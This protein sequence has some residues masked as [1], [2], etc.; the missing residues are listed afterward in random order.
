MATTKA[1]T[2]V[3]TKSST[4][5]A[6][7]MSYEQE[8]EKLRARLTAPSGDRIKI[9]N[10]TFKL[11]SGDVL[12][13]LDAVIVDFVY[14]NK[15]YEGMYD[16]D[17]IVPPTCFAIS[18]DPQ[19]L[20]PSPNSPEIQCEDGCAGCAM[21]QWGSD[22]KGKACKNRMLLAL[23]PGDATLDTP[24]MLLDI[25]PTAVKPFSA[26]ASSV[27]RGLQRP[28]YGVL[29]KIT[30]NPAV[31]HDQAQFSDPQLIDD[32]EFIDMIRSRIPEARERLMVE[33]DV[34]AIQAANDARPAKGRLMAPKKAAGRR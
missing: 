2:A 14:T 4:A 30:C 16:K 31:K 13:E 12:N 21:N 28:P 8:L 7:P 3:A 22:G 24:L 9:D 25:S 23:L 1:K 6:M 26:Y 34:S 5:V 10:K 29:T 11:P 19:D 32:P 18:A 33:P 27:A 20:K 15:Y 17:N